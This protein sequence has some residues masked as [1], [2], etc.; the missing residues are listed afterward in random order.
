MR[1]EFALFFTA[2]TSIAD[3]SSSDEVADGV[4]LYFTQLGKAGNESLG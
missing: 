2:L 4:Q 3:P 1:N